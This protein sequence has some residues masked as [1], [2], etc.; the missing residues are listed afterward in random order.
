MQRLLPVSPG[1]PFLL[2]A[3]AEALHRA[4]VRQ[5]LVR[6]PTLDGRRLVALLNRL[7]QRFELIV[8]ARN[9][10]GEEIAAA[11]GH[12]LHLPGVSDVAA[13]RERF[14][15]LLGYSA[16]S[17]ED[18]LY[19]QAARVDYVTLSPIFRPT[20]KPEDDRALLGPERAMAVQRGVRVKVFALG[21]VTPERFAR[22]R[23]GGV[24]GC[25]VLGGLFLVPDS[26]ASARAL[27][28]VEVA[29][30]L[31]LLGG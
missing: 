25:A 22:L 16:H 8:H 23:R 6:E 20:S 30:Q 27:L 2:E 14:T 3:R 11:G 1:D 18:V 15:G 5:L 17:E 7:S 24:F 10:H 29:R 13:V 21:G 28:S 19:A 12:G 31:S 26:E 4:G 9:R